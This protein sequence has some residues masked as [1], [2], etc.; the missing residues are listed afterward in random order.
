[1]AIRGFGDL[2]NAVDGGK[3]HYQYVYKTALPAPATAGYFIDSNQSSGI[4]VYNAFAGSA[5][6]FTPLT[7][8]RNQ[9]VYIGPRPEAGETKR[10]LRW[11]VLTTTTTNGPPSNLYLC[12]YLGFYPLIDADSTDLQEMDNSA[13]IGR[14]DSGDGV[15]VVFVATAPMTSTAGCTMVYTN[16]D[17]TT[18]RSVTFNVIPAL[19]IGVC[20]TGAGTGVGAAGQ[21]SPFVNLA[22]GDTGVR[23][24]ESITFTTGAGGF[25]CACLVK[26]LATI[27]Y[28]E[29]S[30]PAEKM[31][32]FEWQHLPEIHNDAY[33][34]FLIQ[35]GANAATTLQS[36][37]V[38]INA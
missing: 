24:I 2:A 4:P 20:A 7:G 5:L 19:N 26:P 6:T 25:I 11:Q 9:G 15:R 8:S 35:R 17:G 16:Q 29:S 28:Y 38:F 3:F 22:G 23:A 32:G 13:E 10:L 27:S 31:F 37:L 12:D 21:A 30:V 1:M 33:L 14:Y 18:G 34:N 36:E